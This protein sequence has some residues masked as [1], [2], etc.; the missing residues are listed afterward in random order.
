MVVEG[1]PAA[2]A[3]EALAAQAGRLGTFVLD[4]VGALGAH[5]GP[6]P[7]CRD[8]TNP[9]K[10]EHDSSF[11]QRTQQSCYQAV[12]IKALTLKSTFRVTPMYQNIK[13]KSKWLFSLG[14]YADICNQKCLPVH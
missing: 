10:K 4:V 14:K 11:V 2:A 5:L 6:L 13:I 7:F 9:Q 8:D 3:A 12:L 1:G